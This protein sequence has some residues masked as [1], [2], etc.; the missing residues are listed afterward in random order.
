MIMLSV[1]AAGGA[2]ALSNLASSARGELAGAI[3]V[4]I[5]EANADLRAEQSELVAEL[6]LQDPAVRSLRRIPREE[7]DQMME[8]WLGVNDAGDAIPIPDLI[9]VQLQ[10]PASDAELLRLQNL[11]ANGA[12]NSR[13]DAQSDLLEPVY[14]ALSALLYLSL[15][16]ILLLA[17]ASSAAVWLASRS[18]FTSNRETME[19]VHLLGGADRQIARIF[20]RSVA[21]DALLGA[22]L[23][24]AIGVAVLLLV[25]GQFAALDSGMVEGGGFDWRDWLIISAIP[26]SGILIAIMTA[27]MTVMSAL[28]RM[29]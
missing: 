5:I 16:L 2:L 13:I 25:A 3:T 14:S 21:L 9:D 12:P 24:L 19:I 23:G 7:L 20:Q 8:P 10:R 29:L 11:L 26:T 18:A 1:L 27:R 17:F 4:Q 22:A 28:R 15:G 6:L